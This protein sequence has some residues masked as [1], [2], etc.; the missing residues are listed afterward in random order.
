MGHFEGFLLWARSLLSF[1]LMWG[2]TSPYE[3][4]EKSSILPPTLQLL[5]FAPFA[6][7]LMPFVLNQLKQCCSGRLTPKQGTGINFVFKKIQC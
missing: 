6:W 1:S 7:V 3:A 5:F 4:E 2:M